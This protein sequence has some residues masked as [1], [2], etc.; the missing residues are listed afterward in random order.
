MMKTLVIYN[1]QGQ[2]IFTQTN[3]TDSYNCI[4]ENVAENKEIVGVD[5]STGK[6]TLVDKLATTEEKEAIKRELEEKNKELEETKQ[7]LL[8][9]QATIVDIT[10]N[11]L[12][13]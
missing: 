10:A 2:L 4:V 3:A 1:Q 11:N 5:V 12:L 9:T 6:C 7:K 8:Q 13:K